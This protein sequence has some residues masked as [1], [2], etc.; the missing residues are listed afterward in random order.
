MAQTLPSMEYPN[1]LTR[2]GLRI[3]FQMC[4]IK[5]GMPANNDL[6]AVVAQYISYFVQRMFLFLKTFFF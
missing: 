1:G 6:E 4:I 3:L 5:E 2:N